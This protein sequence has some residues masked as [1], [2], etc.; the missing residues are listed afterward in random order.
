MGA[1]HTAGWLATVHRMSG[2]DD[3]LNAAG[4]SGRDIGDDY[5]SPWKD[6]LHS[7]FPEF[8]AFFFP[9]AGARI[10]W[11]QPHEFLDTELR[12]VVQDAELGRRH[13]DVLVRVTTL[14]GLT[15]HVYVHVEV[16]GGRESDFARRMFVYHYRLF[17]RFDAPVASFAVLADDDPRWKPDGFSFE[18][19]GLTHSV[20]F[21]IAKLLDHELRLEQLQEDANPFALVTAAHLLTRRTS[22]D[23]ERRY[24]AKL[25][26]IRLLYRQGWERQQVL[27]LFAVLDWMMRL[28]ATLQQ[29]LW[30]DVDAMDEEKRMAYV[31]TWEQ[32]GIE[33]GREQ[34]LEQGRALGQ[35]ALLE[36]Q[37]SRR[38]GT[39][40][41]E[42]RSLLASAT[43]EQLQ[44]WG[45]RVLDA[46]S[47]AEVFSPH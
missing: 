9:D 40:S 4:E 36:R 13:A 38:F 37:L 45:D 42:A 34:G 10:D 20:Q 35:A 44:T 21:G 39:L 22:G 14:D 12:Q 7:A 8:M 41:E 30:Q 23:A 27:D 33:K 26:L 31:T 2:T 28:P 11:R 5:D 43:P 1:M 47:L 15:E 46:G 16:Q 3:L 19:L 29:R 17:D 24:E 25:R 32:R 18:A 6:I